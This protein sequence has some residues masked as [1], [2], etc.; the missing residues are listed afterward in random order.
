MSNSGPILNF[1][2]IKKVKGIKGKDILNIAVNENIYISSI[3]A[4]RGSCAKCRVIIKKGEENLSPLTNLEKTYLSKEELEQGYRLACYTKVIG[5]GEILIYIPPESRAEPQKMLISGIQVKVKLNPVVKKYFLKLPKATLEDM[6]QDW[7]RICDVIKENYGLKDLSISYEALINLPNVIRESQWCITVV[8]RDNKEVLW[9]EKGDTT[10]RLFGFAIDVGTT[11]LAGYLVDLNTGEVLASTSYPNPQATYGGDV[12]SRVAFAMKDQKNLSLLN[13]L[14]IDATN[15][16]IMELCEKAKVK[17][18]EIYEISVAGN[19]AMHHIY[20]GINPKYI[21]LSPYL[22][23]IGQGISIKAKELGIKVNK[24]AYTYGLPNIAGFVGADAVADILASGIHKSDELSLLIDI[25]TNTEIVLGN[26]DR[27]VSCSTPAG[28][29]I[30]GGHIK[31]GMRAEIGAIEHVWIDPETHEAGYKVIGDVKPRGICGS[32]IIDTVA[33]LYKANIID[34]NGTFRSNLNSKRIKRDTA[35]TEYVIAWA[36]ET[37][38]NRDITF[39]A[40]DVR[41][42]QLVK[43]AIRTGVNAVMDYMKVTP[44][45]IKRLYLAGGFGTYVDPQSA[46]T[47]GMYPDIPLERVR[48][49]GN[50]AGAGAKAALISKEIRE[51]AEEVRKKIEYLELSIYPKFLEIFMKATYLPFKEDL[52]FPI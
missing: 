52:G 44:K 23:T 38:I 40:K 4:G 43:A 1:E 22:P 19:T 25:G 51:E 12:A 30:E 37:A 17:P 46:R 6:R 41:E 34:S 11:K 27:L 20:F 16:M 48:F 8:V 24:E 33:H 5:D 47:I 2:G 36:D 14:V 21:G 28:P 32:A 39:T 49:V 10:A 9:I 3:C 45:D 35:N 15:E 29:A 26:K 50:A 42:I 7:E 31:Y 13:K 18:E